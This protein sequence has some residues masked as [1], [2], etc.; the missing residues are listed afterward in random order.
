MSGF[1]MIGNGGG[2]GGMSPPGSG[3]TSVA[4][5][6]CLQQRSEYCM[7]AAAAARNYHG[8]DPLALHH[9]SYHPAGPRHSPCSPSQPPAY[10]S[11]YSSNT[12]TSTVN[13]ANIMIVQVSFRLAY[14]YRSQCLAKDPKCPYNTGLAFSDHVALGKIL[15]LDPMKSHHA[16]CQP[17]SFSIAVPPMTS[18]TPSPN[19]TSSLKS[20]CGFL[21]EYNCR[22]I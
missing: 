4:A 15:S 9:H 17:K 19:S 6:A 2:G 7:A 21:M 10:H 22:I 3:P 11:Q 12:V 8:G 20:G 16:P 18:K 5:A 13:N 14:Q 1:T